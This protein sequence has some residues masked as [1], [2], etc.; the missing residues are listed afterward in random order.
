MLLLGKLGLAVA[1]A[2]CLVV[3]PACDDDD[4]NDDDTDKD[5]GL[6]DDDVADDEVADDVVDDDRVEITEFVITVDDVESAMAEL[7]E[8]AEQ[9]LK[10]I[11]VNHLPKHYSGFLAGKSNTPI[12]DNVGFVVSNN[13]LDELEEQHIPREELNEKGLQFIRLAIPGESS[14][15]SAI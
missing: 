10:I 8:L 12:L 7:E 5:D 14:T 9:G 6:A 3:L 15:L 13:L 1:V 4:D 2:M 11:F